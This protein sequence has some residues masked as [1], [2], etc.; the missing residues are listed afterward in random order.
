MGFL[1]FVFHFSIR[2]GWLNPP[3]RFPDE[4]CR[5]KILDLIGDF[6][7]LAQNGNGGLPVAHI[8][9]YKVS[10]TRSGK[11]VGSVQCGYDQLFSSFSWVMYVDLFLDLGHLK[12]RTVQVL[13]NFRSIYASISLGLC[14]VYFGGTLYGLL[15]AQIGFTLC[16]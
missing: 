14:F 5:H 2:D 7:L 3:L 10:C 4:P 16:R 15:S 1:T 8:S 13:C 6:S 12:L 11:C 9:A